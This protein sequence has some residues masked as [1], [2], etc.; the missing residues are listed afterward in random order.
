MLDTGVD[1]PEVVNLAFMK[2]V[3]SYVKFWQMIGRGSRNNE[4]CKQHSWLPNGKKERYLII[5]YW[6]NWGDTLRKNRRKEPTQIPV[7]VTILTTRIKKLELLLADQTD[8]A[9]VRIVADLRR[10]LEHIPQ[11]S[12]SVQKAWSEVKD[13]WEDDFW[14]YLT[15]DKL[16]FLQ[17][18]VAPLLRF[19]VDVN[20]DEAFF[21]SKMERLGLL[22]LQRK[23][24]AKQIESIRE[25]VARLPTNL[26]QVD[27][28]RQQVDF[29][30]SNA[31]G[32]PQSL[33]AIDE[34]KAALAPLM[35]YRK[36]RPSNVIELGLDDVI[37]SR[38]WCIVQNGDQRIY[39]EEYKRLVEE[40]VLALA[41][42]HPTIKKLKAGGD[43]TTDDL[44]SLEQTLTTE[45]QSDEVSLFDD[46]MEKAF[47]VRVGSLVDFIR[48]VLNLEKLPTR[49]S[50]IGAA[51]DA[52][53]LEHNFNADQSRFLRAVRVVFKE[54]KK[55]TLEDLYDEPFTN[56][57]ANA[58]EKL[59][60]Q[61]EIDELLQLTGGLAA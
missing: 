55:I 41:E 47:G 37:Q 44:V 13:A 10:E 18:K 16:D 23:D 8:S 6:E 11:T 30:L 50:I 57:G 33:A 24:M 3:S 48:H 43:I 22:L 52:F 31:F 1:I 58:V 49:E 9:F 7:L 60:S 51:F 39:V 4:T 12:F 2:P 56:F 21:I 14:R 36:D 42:N 26:S 28:Q 61:Q 25:D 32:Q 34:T 17:M 15:A 27:E 53:V 40:R 38:H 20:P 19:A 59:F 35:K 46:N 54:R 5:D 45:L 29:V